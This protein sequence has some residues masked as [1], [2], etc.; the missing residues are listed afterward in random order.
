MEKVSFEFLSLTLLDPLSSLMNW[1]LAVECSY[2][3][4]KLKRAELKDRF[5]R[6]WSWFFAGYAISLFF[7]G[8]S[9]LLFH[10]TG[11]YG[12]IPGW[13]FALLA[14]MAGELALISHIHD[15]KRRMRLLTIIRSMFFVTVALLIY[16]FT[17]KWVMVHTAGMSFFMVVISLKQLRA[18]LSAYKYFLI[19][20]S[21]LFIMA[22]VNIAHIDIHPAWFN[23]D[24]IAHFFML[25]MYWMFYRGVRA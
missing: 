22:F 24:D 13:C 10:Y 8:F 18:G 2:F 23:R 3:F 5:T 7:G 19:G 12:K 20:I 14:N 4:N 25:G 1:V 6:Y 9:H 15:P 17:F 16:D 21:F 11:I